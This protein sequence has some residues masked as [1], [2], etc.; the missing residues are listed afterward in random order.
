LVYQSTQLQPS[1]IAIDA[2]QDNVFS[3]RIQTSGEYVDSYRL[4]AYNS[5]TNVLVYDSTSIPITPLYNGETLTITVVGGSINGGNGQQI[6]W[7]IET[8]SSITTSTATSS[9]A[10]IK[11]NATPTIVFNPPSTINSQSYEFTATYTQ[12][13]NVPVSYYK[14]L[15]YDA[16]GTLI[17]ETESIQ[18]GRL[19]YLFSGFANGGTYGARIIG[20][21]SNNVSW[22]SGIKTFNVS[23]GQPSII[24][25]PTIT[26]DPSNSFVTLSVGEVIQQTLLSTGNIQYVEGGITP[27]NSSARLQTSSDTIYLSL[28]IPDTFFMRMDYKSD[29]IAKEILVLDGDYTAIVGYDGDKFYYSVDGATYY[30]ASVNPT[31]FANGCIIFVYKLKVVV[32]MPNNTKYTILVTQ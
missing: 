21:T 2:S 10:V 18:T 29:G 13:E 32:K 30:S 1:N 27:N 4:R 15:F 20:S 31:E 9:F 14:Y 23:Y 25:V 26:Q 16:N 19:N 28:P 3:C 7:N 12:S 24:T 6:N 8:T 17:K 22:D 5:I 11:T